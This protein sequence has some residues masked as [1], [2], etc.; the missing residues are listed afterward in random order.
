[1]AL[2]PQQDI[3]SVFG[4]ARQLGELL[5]KTLEEYPDVKIISVS[6]VVHG[7]YGSLIAVIETI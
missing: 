7:I 2:I 1:M 4:E 6:H 5:T 3:V